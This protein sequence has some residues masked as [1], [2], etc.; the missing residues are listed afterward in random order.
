MLRRVLVKTLPAIPLSFVAA[1]F[2]RPPVAHAR[3]SSFATAASK[4]SGSGTGDETQ[5][6]KV[7][8][9]NL[10]KRSEIQSNLMYKSILTNLSQWEPFKHHPDAV[11]L[12]KVSGTVLQNLEYIRI[13]YDTPLTVS[14]KANLYKTFINNV[15]DASTPEEHAVY[16]IVAKYYQLVD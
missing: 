11:L 13:M 3:P 7:F 6:Q 4:D 2:I 8:L 14:R 12:D 16:V 10:Q 5:N 15:K 9:S 1:N